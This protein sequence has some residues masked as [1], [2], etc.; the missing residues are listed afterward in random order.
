MCRLICRHMFHYQCWASAVAA[1]PRQ[2]AHERVATCPNC[3]GR[4]HAIACLNYMGTSVLTQTR[5]V[6]GMPLMNMMEDP[7]PTTLRGQ[8]RIPEKRQPCNCCAH[9]SRAQH[10]TIGLAHPHPIGEQPPPYESET[11]FVVIPST[12]TDAND[13]V[14]GQTGFRA[15]ATAGDRQVD[16]NSA[17]PRIYHVETRLPN[18]KPALLLDIGSVG[19]PGW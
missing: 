15:D 6:S 3:Q 10:S 1:G 5:L 19:T 14:V 4:G 9:P 13:W 11:G 7:S 2:D 18:G 17:V 8:P 12:F 16:G